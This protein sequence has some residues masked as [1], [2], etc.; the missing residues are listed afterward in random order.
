M[1]KQQQ[2]D[3]K[4]QKEEERKKKQEEERKRLEERKKQEL[5]ALEEKKKNKQDVESSE[6]SQLNAPNEL[7]D[8]LKKKEGTVV[9]FCWPHSFD[10]TAKVFLLG[11]FTNWKEVIDSLYSYTRDF[12]IIRCQ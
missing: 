8:Q 1:L 3:K 12:I 11:S 7:L 9:E 6:N 5:E 10:I 4:K 2:E